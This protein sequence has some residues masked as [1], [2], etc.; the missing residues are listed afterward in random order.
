M[1]R[2]ST[3]SRGF[4]TVL[5]ALYGIFAISATARAGVQIIERFSAAPVAYLL[6]LLA[7]FTYIAATILLARR[8]GSSRAALWLCS[9]ELLGVLVVGTL[10]LVDPELFPDA[11]V[12]S[13]FGSGYGYV[14][15]V[16]PVIAITYLLRERR[17]A[18]RP[19]TAARLQA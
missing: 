1:T 19:A 9:A 14:P 7:A 3:R 2:R 12:W 6:S 18:A 10:T 8:G 13:G 4:A 11:T 15:L 16:L 5:V 17:R